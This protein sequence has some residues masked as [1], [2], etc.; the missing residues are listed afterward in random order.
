MR[1]HLEIY[2]AIELEDEHGVPI[3]LD[4]QPV[5]NIS[6]YRISE[7]YAYWDTVTE[8]V[9]QKIYDKEFDEFFFRGGY[10]F[11][12]PEK[13]EIYYTTEDFGFHLDW[14]WAI[15]KI[16]ETS[17]VE[18]CDNNA[19]AGCYKII[20]KE[21]MIEITYSK[22]KRFVDEKERFLQAFEK[23]QHELEEF[24]VKLYHEMQQSHF[25]ENALSSIKEQFFMPRYYK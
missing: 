20:T 15:E 14:N 13:H 23:S 1:E 11:E 7:I 24:K 9:E 10:I 5:D 21:N 8:F 16:K 6:L 3:E 19:G 17:V 2:S 18:I 25:S 4:I 12:H 22:G